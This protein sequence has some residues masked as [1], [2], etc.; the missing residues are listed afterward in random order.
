MTLRGIVAM[1]VLAMLGGCVSIPASSPVM[2]GRTLDGN[3][4]EPRRLFNAPGPAADAPPIEIVRG[5]LR[6]AQDFGQDHSVARSFLTSDKR[7]T[8]RPDA[9][10]VV[11]EQEVSKLP[12]RQA[13][14]G[15]TATATPAPSASATTGAAPSGS[16]TGSP[17][18]APSTPPAS[19]RP[20]LDVG[21]VTVEAEIPVVARIDADGVFQPARADDVQLLTFHLRVENGQWRITD[22]ADGIVISRSD[23]EAT[24]TDV[25]L[26][27]RDRT[28]SF[29]VPQT[30][31]FPITS[32]PAT[33][34]QALLHGPSNWLSA[35]VTTGAPTGTELTA[36]GVRNEGTTLVVD[37]TIRAKEGVPE[38]RQVLSAQLRATLREAAR[39]M[40]F[41]A[42]DVRI[43]V[44]QA[45]FE[46]PL[47]AA[48]P[49]RLVPEVSDRLPV[50]LDEDNRITRLTRGNSSPVEGLPAFSVDSSH[51]AASPDGQ[52]YA[53]LGAKGTRVIS[54]RPG[55]LPRIWSRGE[56]MTAPSF[57]VAGWL[58]SAPI[59]NAGSVRAFHVPRASA[60]S[61]EDAVRVAVPWLGGYQVRSLRVSPEGA[62]ALIVADHQGRSAVFVTGVVRGE[63][64]VPQAL[65]DPLQLIGDLSLAR[66]GSWLGSDRVSVIGVRRPDTQQRVWISQ[67]GG[68]VT[69]GIDA[70][71][72][73]S[74]ST[75]TDPDTLWAQT[76][77]GVAYQSGAGLVPMS[78]LRWP[79]LPG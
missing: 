7:T 39:S 33:V 40:D 35:A 71:Q 11:H 59:D 51:P 57:D 29:L 62:R 36:T 78:G 70:S 25:Q 79:A 27:F 37:L 13:Y 58:W 43:T 74:L 56:A 3:V 64:G 49:P 24:F 65:T 54:V 1:I 42:D 18:S 15:Q 69:E 60:G 72:M 47:E 31:W 46:V 9:P 26:Y 48:E 28:G 12:M 2:T 14:P 50:A 76:T 22:P 63:D 16:V 44:E 17:S 5:F 67:I 52:T 55:E 8:W 53:L 61:A 75:R 19:D 4:R 41:V 73:L 30:R 23:F 66:D 10:V 34:V 20:S 6:A 32:G 45:R 77:T 38:Q 21:L 68:E